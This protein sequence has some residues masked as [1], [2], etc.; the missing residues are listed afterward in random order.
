MHD[1][2]AAGLLHRGLDGLD[3][4]GHQG[5]Q[6]DHL[7]VDPAVLRRRQRHVHHDAIGQ[8][9]Q[10]LALAQRVR[11]AERHGVV[12]G[13][14]VGLRMTGPGRDGLLVVA[15]EGAVVDA[16]GLQE[17]H[18]VVV[19]DGGD[20]Q[21]L[22][23]VGVGRDHRLQPRHV[24]EQGLHAL[25]VGVA[26]ED[27]AA[28]GAADGHGG[29]EVG[30]RAVAQPRRLADQLVVGGVDVVGELDLHDGAQAVGA[31]ADGGAHDAA[32]R[33]RRVEAA[34]QAVLLLQPVGDAEHAPKEAHVLT[35][36]QD[37]GVALQHVVERG[38]QRLDHVH[39]GHVGQNPASRFC[40]SSRQSMSL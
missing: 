20:Q 2:A 18:R 28:I 26:A 31:H 16:L 10:R 38:V 9:G 21:A 5:A 17:E 3:V 37:V 35:E 40:R 7:R 22:G 19:L 36:D 11:L 8:H 12:L 25:G 23:V 39:R 27:A 15:V 34:G 29:G 32:L 4:D 6:V 24:G 14:H 33:D 1:D 30:G 13:R